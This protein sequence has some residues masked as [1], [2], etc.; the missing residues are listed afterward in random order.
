MARLGD[1]VVDTLDDTL[2]VSID[3]DMI[4]G[5][6]KAT[7]FCSVAQ[8]P[9]EAATR[10]FVGNCSTIYFIGGSRG[11]R[12]YGAVWWNGDKRRQRKLDWK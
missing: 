3:K 5:I 8:S 4:R 1:I 12:R 10:A 7:Y 9:E 11:N 2:P 6:Q